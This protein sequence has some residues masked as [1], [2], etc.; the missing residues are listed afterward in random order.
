VKDETRNFIVFFVLAA[1]ILFGGNFL[2]SK[3][4]PRAANPPVTRIVDGKSKIVNTPTGPAATGATNVRDLKIV[5][6]ESPRVAIRT[7]DLQGSINLKGA[8]IDDLTLTNYKETIDAKSPPIRLLSPRGTKNAYFAGFG[9]N[10]DGVT[11]PNGDTVF[12]ASGTALTPTT[13]VVLRW[14]NG[15]GQVFALTF[16]VDDKYMFT[17]RQM[18]GN[19]GPA[20]ISLQPYALVSRSGI[21]TE[22]DTWTNHIGPIGVFDKGATYDITF[23]NLQGKEPSFFAK[24]WGNSAKAGDNFT[25]T[26]GGWLGF[27]DKYFLAA[28][29]PDPKAAVHSGFH[30][31]TGDTFQGDFTLAPRIVA[32]GQVLVSTAKFFA[33]AKETNTLDHYENA[34]GIQHFGK[35]IDWGWFEIVEK[36]IFKYLDW[37]F[38]VVGNFGIAIIL[39]T[40]TIRTLIFPVAQRQFASMAAMKAIQPKM[41][42]LQEKYKDDKARQQQEVMALYKAEKVN[43]L[44]G[45]LPTL[46]QIPIMYSLYKVL[47]LTIEMRHQPFVG[48]I[49]DLSSPDPAT[50]LNLFGYLPIHLPPFLS[51]GVVPVLLG[52][53][54]FFQ[55]KLNPAPMDDA[56]KQVFKIMPWVLMFVM[57]PFA[58]GLQVYWIT[59]N[60]WTVAQQR[61][62]YARHPALKEP[63]KK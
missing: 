32:P 8:R 24:L 41:K 15:K 33:G 58:V 28:V 54:M 22:T 11:V 53:S 63:V 5:Q 29:I 60:L 19:A 6:A 18:V 31:A 12:T 47:L 36:P 14:N 7:A 59:S 3:F 2:S 39:L 61:L 13:P 23:A 44:A 35:A 21:G 40:V 37:L 9:W 1:I 34:L 56:Q 50:I 57:A 45:C 46:I 62:L 25:D 17:V 16:A 38:R 4:M 20:P 55:F 49:H 30:A 48:W 51:I 52:I 42:A 27:G 43:P 26:T 10:G